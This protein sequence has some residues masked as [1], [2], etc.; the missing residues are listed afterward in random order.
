[1]RF[2]SVETQALSTRGVKQP[3]VLVQ[4]APLSTGGDD[5]VEPVAWESGKGVLLGV[6]VHYVG[7]VGHGVQWDTV[8]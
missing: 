3:D 6:E 5:A 4:P 1:M 7:S 2:Q 8:N